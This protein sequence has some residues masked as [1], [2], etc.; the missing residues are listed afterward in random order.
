MATAELLDIA[1]GAARPDVLDR[2]TRL[3]IMLYFGGVLV[4]MGFPENVINIPIGFFMKNRL[5]LAAHQLALFWLIAAIPTYFAVVF[6]FTRDLWSPFGRGDRGFL[7]LF[8]ALGAALCA[9]FALAPPVYATFLAAALTLSACF[10]FIRSALRGLIGTIGQQ[11]SMS[12]QMAAAVSAFETLPTVVGL[13]AGGVLSG[14]V[15]GDRADL[16]ACTLF[17]VGGAILAL[18]AL[19]GLLRPRA[20]FDNAR[21]ERDAASH[22]VDDLKRLVRHAPIYPALLIWLLWQFVPG[23]GTPLQYFLQDT[24]KF[25]DAQYT[26][27][28]ALYFA[29]GVPGFVLYGYL[30]RRFALRTLLIVGAVLALPMMLPLLLIHEKTG[31]LW[32]AAPIGAFG[33]VGGAAF[34]DLIIRSCPKGLQGSMLMAA[35]GALAIDGQLGNLLGTSLYDHFHDFTVCVIAMTATNALILPAILLVPRDL[36]AS[37]DGVSP[38]AVT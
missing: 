29:G 19:Y 22:L 23:L 24:L 17:L 21:R 34:F 2:A 35:V 33:G 26:V 16:G 3:R 32:L 10:L 36:I 38:A 8:G 25:S 31:A 27:W 1:P 9:G 20:V 6:G 37:P 14:L 15:E 4:L 11:H 30:C 12:G 13:V 5:H 28:F 18:V 7:M